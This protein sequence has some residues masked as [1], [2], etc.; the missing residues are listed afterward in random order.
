MNAPLWSAATQLDA[1][2]AGT[3][4]DTNRRIVTINDEYQGRIPFRLAS[5]A[6][7]QRIPS[8]PDGRRSSPPTAQQVL[9]YLRG[10]KSNEGS[11]TTNFRIRSHILGDIVYSGAV[12]VGAP[13]QPY[14]DAGN[15]GYTAFAAHNKS[16]TPMVYVGANDGMMH[17][18]DDSTTANAGKET[19]AF[20]P[21]A[22]FSS[23]T[24]R[25]TPIKRL[26]R[27]LSSSER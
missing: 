10:D 22:L 21:S 16:R 11:G 27:A 5:L 19:W 3:G 2:V 14:D 4:W 24:I 8:T 6:T 26:R 9:D 15:P 18:F 1:L 20:I 13:S 12:P 23:V 17:A 7:S 25:T